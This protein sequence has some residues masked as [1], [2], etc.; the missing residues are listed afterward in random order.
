M[1]QEF[2]QEEK[3]MFAAIKSL[4]N[5][6]KGYNVWIYVRDGYLKVSGK[7]GLDF[8]LYLNRYDYKVSR[9]RVIS[10]T[11][12]KCTDFDI[13]DIDIAL[14]SIIK[15]IENEN[16]KTAGAKYQKFSDDLY[17]DIQVYRNRKLTLED[18]YNPLGP[19]NLVDMDKVNM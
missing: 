13:D 16:L 17:V 1:N 12:T 8:E 19:Q 18:Y 11:D 14:T 5:L 15:H 4:E 2:T 10:T 6:L 3:R 9:I 7:C